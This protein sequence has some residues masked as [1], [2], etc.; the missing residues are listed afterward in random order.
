VDGGKW[1]QR[2]RVGGTRERRREGVG[3]SMHSMHSMY[4][5]SMLQYG[6]SSKNSSTTAAV[7]C[8]LS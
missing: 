3:G 4:R 6:R 1:W 7:G 5:D 2:K 8:M